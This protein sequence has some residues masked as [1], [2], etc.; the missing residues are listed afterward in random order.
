M[1]KINGGVR[2]AVIAGGCVALGVFAAAGPAMAKSDM[3][4]TAHS[5]KVRVG[6]T[7]RLSAVA[8]DDGAQYQRLCV[9]RQNGHSWQVLRCVNGGQDGVS[10]TVPVKITH[11]GRT[12]FRA[13][14]FSTDAHH[15]HAKLDRT[16]S[17]VAV[18]G[19]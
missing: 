5:G 4:L 18:T 9:E 3:S 19:R 10:L 17:V 6:Q 13:Q 8:G 14:L 12:A 16:S 11:K 7:A 1:S 2:A 15:G